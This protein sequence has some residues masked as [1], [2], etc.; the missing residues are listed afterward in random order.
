MTNRKKITE[1]ALY[2]LY[3][4]FED[5]FLIDK[6]S[7]K[8]LFRTSFYGDA[9]CGLIAQQEWV[10]VA[11]NNLVIWIDKKLIT[12]NDDELKWIAEIRQIGDYEVEILTD[13]WGENPVIWKFNILNKTKV[14]VRDFY[15]YKNKKYTENIKW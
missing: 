13:P 12:I 8:E 10:V 14:K 15:D 7:Q 2:V 4:E 3:S 1:T 11:G 5:V 9:S 6:N